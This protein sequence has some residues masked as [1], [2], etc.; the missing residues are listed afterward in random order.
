VIH[1]EIILPTQARDERLAKLACAVIVAMALCG[2]EPKDDYDVVSVSGK[3]QY[4]VFRNGQPASFC[5]V[6]VQEAAGH[7]LMNA[8][9]CVPTPVVPSR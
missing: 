6:D 5:E 9:H 1:E 2:C 8:F 4:I 3:E 7:G